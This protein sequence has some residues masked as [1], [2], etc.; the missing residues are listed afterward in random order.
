M[1]DAE[2]HTH[3][4][5][6]RKRRGGPCS[7]DL[8]RHPRGAEVVQTPFGK[9][10]LTPG[11]LIDETTRA[12]TLWDGPG[13]LQ[14]IVKEHGR[15]GEWGETILD[16]GAHHGAFPVWLAGRRAWRIVAVEPVPA[17]LAR[18]KANLDLNQAT[19]A[20]AVIPIGIAA[21]SRADTLYVPALDPG[22]TGG[23]ALRVAAEQE[24]GL[25]TL[26][27]AAPLDGYRLL[28]GDRVS[29]VVI[30]AQGCDGQ[31]I[32]GLRETLRRDHPAVVFEWDDALAKGHHTRLADVLG[33]LVGLGY[34]TIAWPSQPNN[35]LAV[36]QPPAPVST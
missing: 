21:Y 16:V 26:V 11:D 22:N 9:F 14:V 12:G 31:A 29:L 3:E 17:T 15:I 35:F 20:N 8:S 36:A 7:C 30:D 25:P 24:I 1:S 19:C 23:T 32:Y 4:L 10:L 28:F 5:G 18:L 27:P 34:E 33:H 13:F 2:I 6:C